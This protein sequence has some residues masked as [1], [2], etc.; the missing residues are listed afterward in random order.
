[1]NKE[2]LLKIFTNIKNK[3][4]AIIGDL[5][6]DAY[7]WGKVTRISPEA[8]VPVVHVNKKTYCL[9]GAA[10]VMRNIVSLGGQ[11]FAFG[12]VGKQENGQLLLQLI[13]EQNINSDNII[14]DSHYLT[15]EKQRIMA[16]SQQLVRVDYEDKETISQ[17]LRDK[18]TGKIIDLINK[19]ELD[20]I[21]FE[22]YAKGLI[23][24]EMISKISSL[25]KQKGIITALDP[26]PGHKLDFSGL[27]L[28][29][30]NQSEAFTLAGIYNKELSDKPDQDKNL[31]EVAKQLT[32]DWGTEQLLITLGPKGMVLFHKDYSP[33]H[34]P[35]V[36]KEV[37]DVTGAGDTVIATYTLGL[38][39]GLSGAESAELANNAA[40]IVVGRIGTSYVTPEELLSAVI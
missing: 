33:V 23:T 27:T 36:A 11:A 4:I 38:L 2:K 22:D 26:H 32:S 19:K 30:P 16:D 10:N 8:P 9:G 37:Y 40:G 20:A 21:I 18:L 35:T 29:T 14:V 1:M 31:Y 7:I 24:S 12:V 13:N 34:I 15:I 5:M 25:A 39:G 6:L 3:K 28:M 17:E